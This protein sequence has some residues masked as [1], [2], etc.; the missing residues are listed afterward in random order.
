MFSRLNAQNRER[1]RAREREVYIRAM[2]LKKRFLKR[3][4][5]SRKIMC[6]F[7]S[8]KKRRRKKKSVW[9]RF[10][11]Y[12]FGLLVFLITTAIII[13]RNCP[14]QIQRLPWPLYIRVR[15]FSHDILHTHCLKPDLFRLRESQ[16]KITV[17]LC[18]RGERA[19]RAFQPVSC[20]TCS[21]MPQPAKLRH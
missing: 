1:E 20:P 7:P 14:K 10:K 9:I 11:I 17:L 5:F 3:R 13:W 4:R 21:L 8:Q 19:L 16:H 2:G 15:L 6:N 12:I 18:I